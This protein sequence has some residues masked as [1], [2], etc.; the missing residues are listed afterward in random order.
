MP[1]SICSTTSPMRSASRAASEIASAGVG[2]A[3]GSR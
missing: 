1:A 2:I 3:D